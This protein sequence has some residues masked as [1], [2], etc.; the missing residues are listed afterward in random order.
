MKVT[1]FNYLQQI[2]IIKTNSCTCTQV[3]IYEDVYH[4][5]VG[6]TPKI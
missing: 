1:V 3:D 5:I 6:D 2:Q 4:S